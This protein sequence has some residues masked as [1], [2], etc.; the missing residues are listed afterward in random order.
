MNF[1]TMMKYLNELKLDFLKPTGVDT[2]SPPTDSSSSVNVDCD[3]LQPQCEVS[4]SFSPSAEDLALM[5]SQ[6]AI[7]KKLRSRSMRHNHASKG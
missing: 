4:T 2:V 5:R 7:P 6:G 3:K 1:Q